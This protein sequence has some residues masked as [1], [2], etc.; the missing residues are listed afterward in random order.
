MMKYILAFLILFSGISFGQKNIPHLQ[1]KGETTQLI[2]DNNPFIILGG[3]LGNST[4]SDMT[5]LNKYWSN[6]KVLHLNT[7][8]APVY[9]ELIEPVENQFDFTLPDKLILAARKHNL[10]LVLLWFASWKNSMSCYVP[11]WVKT[12][13]QRFPRARNKLGIAQ[14][15]L[16][17]FYKNNL[18]ADLK[19][20]KKLLQHLKDFDSA[21]QTVIMIQVENEIAMLPDA[22]DWSPKANEAF[23]NEVPQEL[24]SYLQ[25]N[26]TELVPEMRDLWS[27]KGYKTNG[28]WTDI[29]GSDLATDEVFIAWYLAKYTNKIVQAGKAVYP[30]PM[31]VNAALNR[32][33]VNP[34]DYPSGGPLPHIMDIWLAAAPDIDFL[35]PDFYFPN[36]KHWCDLYTRRNNPLF[37]PEHRFD[38]T[39]AAKAFFTIGHYQSLGF[40]PFSIESKENPEKEPL[41]Q[42][43]DIL[44]QLTPIITANHG[45]RKV[46]AV[47]LDKET[48]STVIQ[49]GKYHFIFEHDYTLGWSPHAKDDEWPVTG[50]VILQVAEDTFFIA[51][52]GVVVTF[53]PVESSTE[54]AG[55]LRIDEGRFENGR[56]HAG[57]R[58]N[59][60]QSH[61]GRH[62]RIPVN[63]FDIQKLKLYIYD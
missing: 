5:Y 51:G 15:I 39:A 36:I 19:A 40:S 53:H 1:K 57:R 10:K 56:W 37:I 41:G 7:V 12:D 27:K 42:A 55:I 29:F 61:Q 9:W 22:R 4:A 38:E 24:T 33:N 13:Q 45:T 30:L 60:D 31:Y 11:A 48:F 25:K 63:E 59:G 26:K 23:N 3:E 43:Y 28:T 49:M 18:T 21:Q 54:K 62:L 32:P 46:N 35:S 34:G 20:F 16:S 44:S 2:V 6:F 58:M 14:E 47:L 8:I 50:A 17:P 52:T